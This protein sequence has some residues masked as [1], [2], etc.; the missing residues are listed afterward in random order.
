M[1][2]LYRLLSL[3]NNTTRIF[4]LIL[5]S[6]F[7]FLSGYS[8]QLNQLEKKLDS[9][10][11]L[12]EEYQLKIDNIQKEYY[13]LEKI[14][15]QV[16]LD[17]TIGELYYCIEGT[18]VTKT[19]DKYEIVIHLPKNSKVK[20]LDYNESHYK[21]KFNNLIGWVL[22]TALIP[23]IEY[24]KEANKKRAEEY[25]DSLKL[26]E[27]INALT[28]KEK[29]K[30]S[31]QKMFIKKAEIERIRRIKLAEK[32]RIESNKIAEIE[33]KE[34]IASITKKYNAT[35]AEKILN[36]EIWLGMTSDMTRE[37][38]GEPTKINKSL[39]SWGVHEQWVYY[40]KYLYFENGILKS[41]Q[42]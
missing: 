18:N 24:I 32:E 33:H 42:D 19:P 22:K 30:E 14:A 16:G 38:K 26:A 17:E 13:N 36:G 11:L 39:G 34:R 35:I 21:I 4:L 28:D 2:K 12:K 20:L 10:R 6:L 29:A 41:W 37:S 8:Q 3:K 7:L 40:G 1:Y 23:G 31:E 5:I 15:N 27:K 9:L 25:A